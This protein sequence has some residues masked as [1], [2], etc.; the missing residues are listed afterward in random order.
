MKNFVRYISLT[1]VLV[2][3]FSGNIFAVGKSEPQESFADSFLSDEQQKIENEALV[4]Y[5]KLLEAWSKDGNQVDIVYPD[6]F[7]G[8]Y[9]NNEHH[10]VIQ[11]TDYSEEVISEIEKIVSLDNVVIE[12][13][14]YSFRYLLSSQEKIEKYF[15]EDHADKYRKHFSGFGISEPKNAVNVYLC[16][17]NEDKIELKS[18]ISNV[19]KQ[20]IGSVDYTIF[21]YT[22]MQPE[23]TTLLYPG[24]ALPLRSVGFWA[25]D[26][27]GNLGI[28]TAPHNSM[29][30][31]D[32]VYIN[33]STFGTCQ[34]AVFSGNV[35]AAFVRRTNSYFQPTRQV[36]GHGETL[37]SGF[38]GTVATGS[39]IY[40][41][42]KTTGA[43]SGTVL[44]TNYTCVYGNPYNVTLTK[45]VLTNA[46]CDSGDS[47]GV[48]FG[49]GT[50]S[51]RIVLGCITGQN[52]GKLIYTKAPYIKSVLNI[53]IY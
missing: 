12:E 2:L 22:E 5:N 33:G 42:G 4:K 25:Q 17:N 46:S 35:D 44:D 41:R 15:I 23:P 7:G 3:L 18:E 36:P 11:L 21:H 43:V 47:G 10:L 49:L 14:K 1:L 28:V 53:T 13:V 27:N 26:S 39:T 52:G 6:F 16:T 20:L 48:V 38:V 40:S 51:T 29:H 24:D 19:I 8:A 34:S 30:V 31:G 50:P 32:T 45:T 37:S 9:I